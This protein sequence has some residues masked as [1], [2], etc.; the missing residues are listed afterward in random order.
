MR[1]RSRSCDSP[2][3]GPLYS[4]SGPNISI[5]QTVL[6]SSPDLHDS[7]LLVVAMQR[8]SSS[9]STRRTR[10]KEATSYNMSQVRSCDT[11]I[12]RTLGREMHLLGLRYRKQFGIEGKPDFAYP[13]ERVAVF[14]DSSFWH[15]RYWHTD[16]D[17]R[18]KA[19]KEFWSKKILRNIDRD[20]EVNLV[21]KTQGWLVL[22]FWDSQILK[23]PRRCAEAVRC[24]VERRKRKRS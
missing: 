17:N 3:P 22:R 24:A 9:C 13:S 18:P 6:G 5:A 20:R 7:R 10:S 21:L 1:D 16:I 23:D 2:C 8:D 12:E 14:C 15:G 11:V 4:Y 19:N